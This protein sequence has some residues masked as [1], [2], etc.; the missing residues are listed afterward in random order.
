MNILIINSGS[1]SLKFQ[2]FSMEKS[3]VL[4]EGIVERIAI[5]GSFIKYETA[6]GKN[7][8]ETEMP[9][10][11]VALEKVLDAI[12]N[13]EKVIADKSEINAIGHR[14]VHGG[15]YFTKPVV[16]NDDVIA[17][18]EECVELAPLHNPAHLAGI[19]GCKEIFGDVPQVACF[20]TAFH[21]TMP[22][23]KFLYAIPGE[24]Y[25]K[26]AIRKYGFHGIS[27]EY[28]SK[29]A[30]ELLGKEKTGKVITCHVWNG[31]SVAAILDGRVINTSM[32]FTP[33]D[34]LVMGTR[35]GN[36]DASVVTFLMNK[37]GLSATEMNEILNKKSGV[38]GISGKS[39]DMRDIEDGY[40]A[41]DEKYT[42]AMDMY[43]SRIVQT[44]GQY[45]A[46][47]NGVDTIIFTAGVLE[48]SGTIRELI[49]KKLGFLGIELKEGAND[50]RGEERV[51]ST[52]DSKATVI[53][54]PTNEEKMI[55]EATHALVK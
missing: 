25:E 37:E 16:I 36:I 34:G 49:V 18:I 45:V 12:L 13:T 20:D 17:K 47:L 4:I 52:D 15:Q 21:Q 6:N 11:T 42:L 3:E 9:N 35:A 10:H 46:D 26:H 32:G 54:I 23:E 53:V 30:E 7:K 8:V 48:N 50:F 29:R 28:I 55:A 19:Y 40:A 2:L 14:V 38:L 51:I 44:I 31:A 24:Y 41:G 43:V 5:D 1:S 33:L 39:S 22:K 27:H